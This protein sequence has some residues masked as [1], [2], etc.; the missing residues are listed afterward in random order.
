MQTAAPTSPYRAFYTP[1]DKNGWPV[2]TENGV[3]PFVRLQAT[4][5]EHAIRAAQ[6]ATGCPIDSVERLDGVV[7]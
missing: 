2:A 6:H 1:L 5:A 7:A 4:S 3:L